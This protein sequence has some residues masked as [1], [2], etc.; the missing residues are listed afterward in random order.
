MFRVSM[1]MCA[2]AAAHVKKGAP[3][4]RLPWGKMR[5]LMS[6][7]NTAS[8]VV[9]VSPHVRLQLFL[10]FC[11]EPLHHHPIL[12]NFLQN[13][14]LLQNH[15]KDIVNIIKSSR[16]EMKSRYGVQ[17]AVYVCGVSQCSTRPCFAPLIYVPCSTTGCPLMKTN[18]IPMGLL[19]V[20]VCV[21]VSAMV[22]GFQITRSA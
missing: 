9:S 6:M 15:E 4:M 2:L 12:M 13:D 19:A 20:W 22:A 21:V 10:L 14:F 7:Q 5:K 18:S 8:A 11:E 17:P 16:R 3:W 1:K